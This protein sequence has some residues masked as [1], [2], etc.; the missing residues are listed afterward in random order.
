MMRG[1]FQLL[2]PFALEP[3]F[4]RVFIIW[5]VFF[6]IFLKISHFFFLFF[7]SF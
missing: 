3:F 4:F 7:L 6:F 2:S 1:D 5:F